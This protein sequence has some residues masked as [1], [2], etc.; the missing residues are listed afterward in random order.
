M[1]TDHETARMPSGFL[2]IPV[3][4][5]HHEPPIVYRCFPDVQ[6]D[7]PGR[8]GRSC[9]DLVAVDASGSKYTWISPAKMWI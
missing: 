7:N 3:V 2:T 1:L 5:G 4:S 8:F 9:A 6:N